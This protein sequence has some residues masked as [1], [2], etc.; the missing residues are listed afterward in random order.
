VGDN[1][2]H[3]AGHSKKNELVMKDFLI[4]M[5]KHSRVARHSFPE[6]EIP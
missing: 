6:P 4:D 2:G 3:S 5:Q 1:R